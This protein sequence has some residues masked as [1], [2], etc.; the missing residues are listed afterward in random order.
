MKIGSTKKELL[1][2]GRVVITDNLVGSNSR[3]QTQRKKLQTHK[4]LRAMSQKALYLKS[5][6]G[7][8]P[9]IFTERDSE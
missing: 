1:E 2:T 6:Q 8:P 3:M 7:Q 5:P 4:L 9:H